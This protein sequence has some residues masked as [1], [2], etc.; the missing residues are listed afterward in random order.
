[1][2]PSSVPSDDRRAVITGI[3]V[4]APS[5]LDREAWWSAT[6]A[7]ES[8]IGPI[9]RFDPSRYPARLA[10]EVRDFEPGDYIDQRLVK[11]TDRWTWMALA[12]AQAALDDAQVDPAAHDPYSMSVITASS[13]GGNEFGQREIEALWGKGPVFVGAYQSI[14]WFYAAT[15]GQVSIKHGMKGPSGVVLAEGAGG[16]EALAHSRRTIRRGTEI[17]VSGGVEAPIGPYALTC[18]LGTGFLST[19]SDAAAAYRPFDA[20]ANGYVPGEGGA[21]LI[22]ESLQSAQQRSAPR[23]YG[24]ILGYGATNDA[25]HWGKPAPDGVQSARAM[26]VALQNAGITPGEVDA[27]IADAFGVPEIDA[28]E[29]QAIRSV[30]G[31]HAG[32]MPVL[33]P[34]SGVGRLYAGGAAL[35]AAA[36]LLCMRD[37]ALPPIVN[38]DEPAEGLGLDFV[39]GS[40]RSAQPATILVNARGFGGFNSAL[41]LRRMS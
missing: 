38:L 26:S 36:A 40:E 2:S 20:R 18:Q 4:V 31:E 22:V 41:V 7:G 27:V 14:A 23:I 33:A 5:G 34:K 16:L 10:G 9:E 1:M 35:D 15:T 19:E 29:A 28:L 24:E 30:F 11:Q 13:S 39:T 32:S 17:V 3:G 25:H 21:I 12:A 37:G 6:R 8:A